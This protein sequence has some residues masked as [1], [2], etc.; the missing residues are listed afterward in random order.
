MRTKIAVAVAAAALAVV[1]GCGSNNGGTGPGRIETRADDKRFESVL[2][3]ENV[4]I[5]AKDAVKTAHNI[6]E[7]FAN[8]TDNPENV[9]PFEVYRIVQSAAIKTDLSVE[10]ASMLVVASVEA[11]CP[12]YKAGF[13]K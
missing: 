11:Y 8:S 10:D 3:R 12:E 1:T 7:D 5:K 4:P 9:D 13:Q 2:E 6:C